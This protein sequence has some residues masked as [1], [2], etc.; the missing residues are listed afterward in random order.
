[1]LIKTVYFHSKLD[2][3][4]V[5]CLFLTSFVIAVVVIIVVVAVSFFILFFKKPHANDLS[6]SYPF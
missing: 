6:F 5:F 4:G 3:C 2:F 1:M